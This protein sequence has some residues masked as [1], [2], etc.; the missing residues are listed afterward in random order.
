MAAQVE[1]RHAEGFGQLRRVL[2]IPKREI[3]GQPMHHDQIFAVALFTIV[4]LDIVQA[5][6]IDDGSRHFIYSM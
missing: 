1:Q 3:G 2:E 4:H 6:Y 5:H